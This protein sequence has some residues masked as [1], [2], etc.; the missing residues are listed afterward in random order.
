MPYR[1][2]PFD[3]SLVRAGA[4][5]FCSNCVGEN[6]A[7]LYCATQLRTLSDSPIYPYYRACDST[8]PTMHTCKAAFY[9]QLATDEPV[10]RIAGISQVK[11]SFSH[12]LYAEGEP[13]TACITDDSPEIIWKTMTRDGARAT[14][15]NNGSSSV[16]WWSAGLAV[17]RTD[18]VVS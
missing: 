13:T 2:L 1:S 15:H 9:K 3:P 16:T 6:H 14:S 5:V 8:A 11:G 10:Q 18:R 7:S 17:L 12:L 4:L